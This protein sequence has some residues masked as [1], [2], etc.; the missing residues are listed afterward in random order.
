LTVEDVSTGRVWTR[1][2][3]PASEFP[4]SAPPDADEFNASF[5]P[6]AHRN[7]TQRA[8][9]EARRSL[10]ERVRQV[11]AGYAERI[12]AERYG[13]HDDWRLPTLEEA[14][15]LT[16]STV[17]A[18]G[19][20]LSMLFTAEPTMRT[21]DHAPAPAMLWMAIDEP[22]EP[23]VWV[24]RFDQANAVAVPIEARAAL[25]FVRSDLA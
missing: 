11:L 8:A 13:G 1:R 23:N 5:L 9:I 2:C 20:H 16:R 6:P 19:L 14:M 15:S 22:D 3:V 21:C 12:N 17:R 24:V 4:L 18:G 7:E 25:R 10:R